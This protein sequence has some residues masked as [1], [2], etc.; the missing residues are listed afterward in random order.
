MDYYDDEPPEIDPDMEEEAIAYDEDDIP[1]GKNDTYVLYMLL[2]THDIC[3]CC[4]FGYRRYRSGDDG[5]RGRF[6]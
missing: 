4:T 3:F 2:L 5:S 1:D 6:S